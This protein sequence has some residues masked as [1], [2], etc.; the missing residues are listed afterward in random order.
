MGN[1]LDGKTA[2]ITGGARGI[3]KAIAVEMAKEGAKIVIIDM[4][5][6]VAD[7]TIEELKL[8]Q[9]KSLALIL[10]LLDLDS[11]KSTLETIKE[12]FGSIDIWVNNAGIDHTT[13]IEDI[14]PDMYDKVMDVNLKTVFFWSQAVFEF[15][16][17]QGTGGSLIHMSSMAALRSG[18]LSS[19][20]YT[21]SKAGVL[22]ASK[23]FAV[24]GA[25][26]GIRSNSILPGFIRTDILTL[27]EEELA[28]I[29]APIPMKRL[30]MPS[31]V[32]GVAVFLASDMSSYVS[33]TA[34]DVNG[35]LYI[36]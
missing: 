27:T 24:A 19:A 36:H 17:E 9:P 11:V 4:N 16:K 8:I 21:V 31:E 13:P 2:V 33:G 6:Q 25:P 18:R 30:G 1:L 3:G 34:I 29:A 22:G 26:Y 23:V 5:K 12:K 32:A 28:Q 7:A 35:A 10:N 15:M 14:S 20:D